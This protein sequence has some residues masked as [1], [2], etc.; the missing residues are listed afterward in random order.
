MITP[1]EARKDAVFVDMPRRGGPRS[2]MIQ[3]LSRRREC[4][5]QRTQRLSNELTA[6]DPTRVCVEIADDEGSGIVFAEAAFR[7]G[8]LPGLVHSDRFCALTEFFAEQFVVR[9]GVGVYDAYCPCT[10]RAPEFH[11]EPAFRGELVEPRGLEI[12]IL[13]R[14]DQRPGSRGPGEGET[15]PKEAGDVGLTGGAEKDPTRSG[16]GCG[17]G[18]VTT[19]DFLE[20]NNVGVL[21]EPRDDFLDGGITPR[22]SAN[23]VT[24]EAKGIHNLRC[25][26]LTG[27]CSQ[28]AVSVGDESFSA[29]IVRRRV[30]ECGGGDGDCELRD[31]R[32]RQR[33]RLVLLQPRHYVFA[34]C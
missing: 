31:G 7:D 2:Q 28:P 14:I 23:V 30:G 19:P 12:R 1:V 16:K 17:P 26:W 27:D 10:S 34:A 32:L 3:M 22:K 15:R 18:G 5:R 8:E 29:G 33:L 9:L 6:G 25:G 20:R 11:A 13:A 24:H 4:V 21:C